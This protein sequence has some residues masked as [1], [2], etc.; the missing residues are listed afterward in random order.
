MRVIVK[1][2]DKKTQF[3]FIRCIRSEKHGKKV[4]VNRKDIVNVDCL[5]R[6]DLVD[7]TLGR[8]NHAYD[9]FLIRKNGLR[10]GV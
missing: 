9:V 2:Y 1:K 4:I 5:L 6:G 3:G 10:M 8:N 7:F